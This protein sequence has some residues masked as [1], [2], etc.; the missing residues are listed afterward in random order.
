M[1]K[2]NKGILFKNEERLNRKLTWWEIMTTKWYEWVD[3]KIILWDLRERIDE[4][5]NDSSIVYYLAD[6]TPNEL[7]EFRDYI[8]WNETFWNKV[9]HRE[10]LKKYFKQEFEDCDEKFYDWD[11][12]ENRWPEDTGDY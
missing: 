1:F 2:I 8:V 5:C 6:L 7:L 4:L 12:E 3:N 10:D 11:S 9:K